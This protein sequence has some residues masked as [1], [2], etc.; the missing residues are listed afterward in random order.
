MEGTEGKGVRSQETEARS[1][2]GGKSVVCVQLTLINH[3]RAVKR[4]QDVGT[5]T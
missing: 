1:R 2:R 4:T 5:G 3:P